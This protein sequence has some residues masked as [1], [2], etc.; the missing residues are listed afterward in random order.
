MDTHEDDTTI[1]HNGSKETLAQKN[2][3]LKEEKANFNEVKGK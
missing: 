1:M 2:L 3:G